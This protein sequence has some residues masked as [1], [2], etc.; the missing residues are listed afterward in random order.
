MM[1]SPRCFKMEGP[2]GQHTNHSDLHGDEVLSPVRTL[3]PSS[4]SGIESASRVSPHIQRILNQGLAENLSRILFS[5]A[6]EPVQHS[7]SGYVEISEGPRLT[8]H[9]ALSPKSGYAC[10]AIRM[11]YASNAGTRPPIAESIAELQELVF[12]WEDL[13]FQGNDSVPEWTN[14]NLYVWALRGRRPVPI[15]PES[16]EFGFGRVYIILHVKSY[17]PSPIMT[18]FYW[19]GHKAHFSSV[20][21]AAVHAIQLSRRIGCLKTSRQMEGIETVDFFD[22]IGKFSVIPSSSEPSL[23][24]RLIFLK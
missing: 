22:A 12:E 5:K 1:T 19:T 4:P 15:P 23:Q 2:I 13:Y 7:D 21:C 16:I 10:G 14:C 11:E 24:A 18:C 3:D 6:T 17:E 9:S 8:Q 20:A